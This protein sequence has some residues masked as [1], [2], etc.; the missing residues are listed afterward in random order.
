MW[1]LLAPRYD[2]E[3]VSLS[4]VAKVASEIIVGAIELCRAEGRSQHVKIHM[5]NI[6]DREFFAGVAFT[7][8]SSA[9]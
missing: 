2:Y 9:D 7:L 4:D 1:V 5:G 3:T 6:A 8:R